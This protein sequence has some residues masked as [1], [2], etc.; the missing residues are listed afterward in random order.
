MMVHKSVEEFFAGEWRKLLLL[1]ALAE[2]GWCLTGNLLWAGH[3]ELA[4][5]I[6]GFWDSCPKGLMV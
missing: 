6:W 2:T 5:R 1:P 4:L 3:N